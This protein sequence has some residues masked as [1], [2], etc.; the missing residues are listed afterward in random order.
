MRANRLAAEGRDIINLGIGQ[1]DAN[2]PETAIEAARKAL[3]DGDHGYTDPPGLPALREAVAAD[4]HRRLG[5][6]VASDRVF[7]TPGAKPV[8]F[9]AMLR[10]SFIRTPGF[11]SIAR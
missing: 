2:P 3:R 9:F 4:L 8:M 10:K 11:R 1:P 5:V 7:V 6:D